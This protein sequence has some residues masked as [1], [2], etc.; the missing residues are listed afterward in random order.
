MIH[1]AANALRRTGIEGLGR[2]DGEKMVVDRAG[3]G[4]DGRVFDAGA[5]APS[6]GCAAKTSLQPQAPDHATPRKRVG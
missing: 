1:D 5:S 2:S 6:G 4:I 3:D